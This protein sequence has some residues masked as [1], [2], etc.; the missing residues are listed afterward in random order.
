MRVLKFRAVD[1][2]DRS[3]FA[4]QGLCRGLHDARLSRPGRSQEQQIPDGP[5]R[6]IQARAKHL[7]NRHYRLD[8]FVL[9]Y[10]FGAKSRL[11]FLQLRAPFG[12]IKDFGL[13]SH[14]ALLKRPRYRAKLLSKACAHFVVSL[15]LFPPTMSLCMKRRHVR[16][17]SK[18]T[19]EA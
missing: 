11:E 12:G 13:N 8:G 9:P 7:K 2:Y 3:L 15:F 16:I 1:L 4:E 17:R 10:N 6:R 18:P 5:S 19:E 14:C